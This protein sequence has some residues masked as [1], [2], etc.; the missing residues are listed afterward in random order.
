MTDHP[1]MHGPMMGDWM[2][3]GMLIWTFVG[4][5]LLV[6]IV[7]AAIWLGLRLRPGDGER[8]RPDSTALAEVERRYARRRARPRDVPGGAA[9]AARTGLTGAERA[10]VT[11]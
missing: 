10:S 8:R 1:E 11:A 4:I 7:V 3:G 2:W 9:R 6:L 5:A